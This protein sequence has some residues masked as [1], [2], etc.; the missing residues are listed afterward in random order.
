MIA[1]SR[2]DAG[3]RKSLRSNHTNSFYVQ[4][5]VCLLNRK[6]EGRENVQIIFSLPSK[7]LSG[8]A[9]KMVIWVISHLHKE[10][11]SHDVQECEKNI[12]AKRI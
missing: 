10:T 4:G 6:S 3:T 7:W 11:G 9:W 2:A 8:R 5:G 12:Y 1:S